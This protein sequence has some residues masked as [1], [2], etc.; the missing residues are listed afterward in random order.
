[1]T[2]ITLPGSPPPRHTGATAWVGRCNAERTQQQWPHT[3]IRMTVV[4]EYGS[5]AHLGALLAD[6]K[7]LGHGHLVGGERAGLV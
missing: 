6:D 1:M 7:E 5:R 4:W 2:N 3:R